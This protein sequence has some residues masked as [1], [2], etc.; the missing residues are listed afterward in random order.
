[1]TFILL[2]LVFIARARSGL[3]SV[4]ITRWFS[5]RSRA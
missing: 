2:T 5:T 4:I 3:R 1:L